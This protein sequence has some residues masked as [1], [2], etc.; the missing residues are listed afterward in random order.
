MADAGRILIIPRGDY[1]GNL[2]YEK[3]DLVKHKGTSWLAKKNVSGIE[4]NEENS[5]YWQNMFGISIAD[6]LT[7]TE[8]GFALDA[9]QGKVLD[10]KIASQI[11]TLDDKI[12]GANDKLITLGTI[13][14]SEP[15]ASTIPADTKTFTRVTE[16]VSLKAGV[17][18]ASGKTSDVMTSM[19]ILDGDNNL[20]YLQFNT[21]TFTFPFVL[22][23]DANI[24]MGLTN[25]TAKTV[26]KD[27]NLT[28][29][30]L[31]RIK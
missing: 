23:H 13:Y 3:L 1:D 12:N 21:N 11:Q 31:M 16:Y 19:S 14:I 17:Y 15:I 25:S 8:E 10:E 26:V 27:T 28:R 7:T 20:R 30:F 5:E 24:A 9:R 6:N 4:P 29:M 22:S 18:I 2:T